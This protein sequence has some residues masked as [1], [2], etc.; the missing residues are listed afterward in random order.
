MRGLGLVGFAVAAVVVIA[1]IWV[2]TRLLQGT[3]G[4]VSHYCIPTFHP[5]QL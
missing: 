2:V 1:L 5:Q 4:Q 3:R